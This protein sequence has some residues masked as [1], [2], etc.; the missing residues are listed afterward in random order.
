MYLQIIVLTLFIVIISQ[1]SIAVP[2]VDY[3]DCPKVD[4]PGYVRICV[5]N[6]CKESNCITP[7]TQDLSPREGVKP[8]SE[9]VKPYEEGINL[10]IKTKNPTALDNSMVASLGLTN[11]LMLLLKGTGII[12]I[13]IIAALL[14]V[15]AKAKGILKFLIV[16]IVFLLCVA[17]GFLLFQGGFFKSTQNTWQGMSPG[18]FGDNLKEKDISV[19]QMNYLS[20]RILNAAE[21]IKTTPTTEAS[22]LVAE[23]DDKRFLSSLRVPID[24]NIKKYH[25]EEMISQKYEN[26]ERLIF[27]EDRFVFIITGE[28]KL[29]LKLASEI[30]SRY[31]T[32]PTASRLFVTDTLPPLIKILQPALGSITNVGVIEFVI[33]DNG[34]G[35]DAD[36]ISAKNTFDKTECY[37]D[38][39]KVTCK[40]SNPK[41]VQGENN[42]EILAKDI[43]GNPSRKKISFVYDTKGV[44]IKQAI[45]KANTYTNKNKIYFMLTDKT[46]GID[47]VNIDGKPFNELECNKTSSELECLYHPTL[48]QGKNSIIIDSKDLAGNVNLLTYSIYYDTIP[49]ELTI[50]QYNLKIVETSGLEF[51]KINNMNYNIENCTKSDT[52]YLCQSENKINSA[53][54]KD[55]AGNLASSYI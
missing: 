47:N 16:G 1:I 52:T 25:K 11:V 24:G 21:F 46:S 29:I 26:V 35:V 41:L 28:D 18:Y 22:L 8:F 2:C 23:V 50:T 6:F 31:P 42:I 53:S 55:L 7:Q 43:Q 51:V 54:A 30:I 45:P 48:Y 5:D 10:S 40:I 9:T 12:F 14:F 13:G 20:P 33:T 3:N 49:P 36:T 32:E 19:L 37:G 27:D 15:F 4:C 34:T 39:S 38:I 17:G 44:T